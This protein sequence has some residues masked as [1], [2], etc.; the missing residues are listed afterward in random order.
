MPEMRIG[1]L[2]G[3]GW[4]NAY[5]V[6]PRTIEEF[7]K[8]PGIDIWK[9]SIL[10][11]WLEPQKDTYD[12][13]CFAHVQAILDAA[14]QANAKVQLNI[15]Q[16]WWPSWVGDW[17]ADVYAYG[18]ADHG[19]RYTD[20][21]VNQYLINAW[22]NIA[23]RFKNHPALDSYVVINEENY[24]T[25]ENKEL[26]VQSTNLV[27]TAIRE[28][29]SVHRIGIRPNKGEEE[30]LYINTYGIHDIDYGA[31][32]YSTG[33]QW[34]LN[35]VESPLSYTS[36]MYM[37]YLMRVSSLMIGLGKKC[38][39][40]EIGFFK[41]IDDTFGD[42]EKLRGFERAMSIAYD[43]GY[44]DF[45]MWSDLFRFA[46]P[47]AYF[48]RLKAFRD[49]LLNRPRLNRFNVRV[50]NDTTPWTPLIQTN[51]PFEQKLILDIPNEPYYHLIRHLDEAGYS[52]IYMMT[53]NIE[54]AEPI[55]YDSTIR[56]SEISGKTEAEQ[57]IL[58]SNRLI[59][60]VNS[61]LVKTWSLT[62]PEPIET[63]MICDFLY[64][65]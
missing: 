8:W 4:H 41:G 2:E 52:W 21:T 35:S 28:V 18:Y 38:G 62:P 42:E 32:C 49:S 58:I 34:F 31:S 29:D 40:G 55:L 14:Y 53:P 11:E 33:A 24:I 22:K 65:Q 16:G 64:T 50:L 27:I 23:S 46:D 26:Y 63:I 13:T 1:V 10:W 37:A 51:P 60:V 57:D 30:R 19:L 56:L 12:E 17:S 44:T 5:W 59:N 45:M 48:P 25:S 6:T 39:I 61:H 15:A 36:Y 43:M 20:P 54:S 7:Q 3:W 47:V 9:L